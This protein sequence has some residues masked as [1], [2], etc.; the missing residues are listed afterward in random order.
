LT[1]VVGLAEE[2]R[3][4]HTQIDGEERDQLIGV[5]ADESREMADLVDD[6]LIAA[7]S[8]DGAVA[9]FPERTDLSLLASS[10]A[11]NLTVPGDVTLAIDDQPSAAYADPV[12]VRQVIR[13]LLTNA[14]RYGGK[15]VSV[16]FGVTEAGRYLDVSDDGPGI[17]EHDLEA[18]FEPYGRASSG[19]VV[20]GSVGLGLTVSKRLAEIMGGSLT[21]VPS[22][23]CTFRLTVPD[24][25]GKQS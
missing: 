18:I 17:P 11:S 15:Q 19:N 6:L 4:G 5:I 21:Y 9:I 20:P 12:R 2:L 23:G 22:G 25:A 8:E 16:T 24:A 13:N 10:V 14:M 3:A 7:G 1:A